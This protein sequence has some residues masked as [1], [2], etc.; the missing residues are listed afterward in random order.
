MYYLGCWIQAAGG[1]DRDARRKFGP[2][3]TAVDAFIKSNVLRC[4][5]HCS[6]GM[7]R[8]R[9]RASISVLRLTNVTQVAM[10]RNSA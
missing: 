7:M 2:P 10:N 9:V 4:A 3:R 8:E 1:M 6:T 5:R